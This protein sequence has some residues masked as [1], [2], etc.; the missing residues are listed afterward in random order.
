MPTSP[1][2]WSTLILYATGLNLSGDILPS[3]LQNMVVRKTDYRKPSKSAHRG[4]IFSQK[5]Y[6][7]CKGLIGIFYI[8]LG[9]QIMQLPERS[10]RMRH[11]FFFLL[12]PTTECVCGQTRKT[13]EHCWP[14]EILPDHLVGQSK[15]TY[16][17][18]QE[19]II[20]F[21]RVIQIMVRQG[22]T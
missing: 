13:T 21:I 17:L 5:E 10:N 14:T 2:L 18:P 11:I 4:L 22:E 9:K 7:H 15:L 6:N 8:T 3:A 16:K 19:A 1:S 20:R 12:L